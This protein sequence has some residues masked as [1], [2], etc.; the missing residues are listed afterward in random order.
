MQS[1]R[2]HLPWRV[3]C[4]EGTAA[5]WNVT[6]MICGA[7]RS[8]A[9]AKSLLRDLQ[10][11]FCLKQCLPGFASAATTMRQHSA[12]T[13]DIIRGGGAKEAVSGRSVGQTPPCYADL[14]AIIVCIAVNLLA[15]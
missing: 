11:R 2:A 7:G 12:L 9:A 6:S 4:P 14:T 10:A 8:A 13:G 3:I 1:A 5:L 15:G